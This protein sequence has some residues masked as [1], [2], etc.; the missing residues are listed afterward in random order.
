MKKMRMIISMVL[1]LECFSCQKP[2][3]VYL[4]GIDKDMVPYQRGES[5]R[6]VD[7]KDD[8]I[9]LKV[10]CI[11]DGWDTDLGG[12][13][14]TWEQYRDVDMASEYNDVVLHFGIAGSIYGGNLNWRRLH[15]V[16]RSTGISATMIY[17]MSGRFLRDTD[18]YWYQ[19][20]HDSL[21]LGD[22]MY[23]NVAERVKP[24]S[25][26]VYYNK[27]YGVLQVQT[28]DKIILQRIP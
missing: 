23:Y 19:H 6:F 3:R 20:V 22:Q 26:K 27:A 24:D 8:T 16:V 21:L 15:V 17:D 10:S 28:N 5:Y 2:E 11:E 18:S 12:I 4:K 14:E 9:T 13:R 25:Y 1:V 7:G